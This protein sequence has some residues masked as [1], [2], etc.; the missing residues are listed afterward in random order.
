MRKSEDLCSTLWMA[1]M[2]CSTSFR[3]LPS[4]PTLLSLPTALKHVFCLQTGNDFWK[5]QQTS[6]TKIILLISAP[7]WR[8][9]WSD[10]VCHLSSILSSPL[11]QKQER[12]PCAQNCSPSATTNNWC[13]GWTTLFQFPYWLLLA[14]QT[15]HGNTSTP[16]KASAFFP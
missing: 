14:Y 10:A 3:R 15:Y 11:T 6:S 2:F 13:F 12:I 9:N 4:A 16:L 5:D 7:L 1:K 8:Y